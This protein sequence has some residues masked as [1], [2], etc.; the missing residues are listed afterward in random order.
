MDLREHTQCIVN[1]RRSLTARCLHMITN[2]LE[3]PEL[4]ICV[5][6][7][8]S[9]QTTASTRIQRAYA[10][11]DTCPGMRED[12]HIIV[13]SACTTRHQKARVQ[14]VLM[15]AGKSTPMH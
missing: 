11:V 1:P 9:T 6:A 13:R 10:S 14:T 4:E 2:A 7:L 3:I 8:P 5:H 12:M 15:S